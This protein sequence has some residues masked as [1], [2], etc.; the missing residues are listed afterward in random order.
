[1]A[2]GGLK[3]EEEA[4]R[5]LKKTVAVIEKHLEL[6][7]DDTRALDL[8]AGV[9]ARLG[10]R[11]AALKWAAKASTIDPE[12]PSVLYNVACTHA[13]LGEIEQAIDYLEQSVSSGMAQVEWLENDPDLESLRDNERFKSLLKDIRESSTG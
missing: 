7:P 2:Y 5:A 9:Q 4:T 13:A 8:G 11:E 3:R 10:N 6:H 12:N 1:L